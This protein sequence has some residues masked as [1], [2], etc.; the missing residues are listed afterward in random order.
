MPTAL[1]IGASRGI[2]REF[3]RQLLADGWKVWAA[4]R[5]DAALSELRTAGAEALKLDVASAESIATIGWQLDGVKLDLALYVAGVF[6][7]RHGAQEAPTAQAF[8][9]VMHTNVLGAMQLIPTVAP[10]VEA[11]KGRFV[12]ISSGMGSIAESTGSGGWVYRASKAALNMTVKT[13]SLDYPQAIF[14][15]MCPGWVQTDMGGPNATITPQQSVTGMRAVIAS[16]QPA[17][18]GTYRG[19]DGRAIAW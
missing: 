1:V 4:A 17:D 16:L 2:G 10:L 15:A 19:H 13:A 8:D 7:P 3:V 9:Q 12:F 14:L 5:D 11:G 18:S 6:G